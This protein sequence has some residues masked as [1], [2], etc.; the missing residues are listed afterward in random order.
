MNRSFAVICFTVALDA[1]GIGLVLPVL[2]G[3]LRSLGH[4]G[5]VAEHYGLLLSAY[6]LMQFLCSPVLGALSDRFGRR[7]VLLISLAGGAID[8]MVMAGSPFLW[9]LYATRIVAGVTG[10]NMAVAGAI[11]ADTTD[12]TTRGK[13]FG[14]MGAAFGVGFIAGPVLGGW[15]GEIS[16][17]APFVLASVLCALNFVM[18]FFALPE[19]SPLALRDAPPPWRWQAANP[20]AAL[21]GAFQVKALRPLL[22]I[23]GLVAI[24]GQVGASVWVIYGQDR[25]HWTP[26][27]V[28]ASMACFGLFHAGAQ[29]FVPGPL[30]KRFGERL[31]CLLS[32]TVDGGAYVFVGLMT[33]G[34]LVFAATPVFCLGAIA[35]P[36]LQALMTREVDEDGQ[37]QLQGNLAALTSLAGVVAPVGF[38]WLYALTKTA[39]PGVV[40]FAGASLYLICIPLLFLG[41]A[42]RGQSAR[43]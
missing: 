37:G 10:A 9:M 34:W 17:R 25:Y 15:M 41:W 18:A 8:Y 19:S 39:H 7:P 21:A 31:A 16:L 2:P 6:A 33:N 20:F 11:V 23:Y 38:T 22:V 14:Q 12:A 24:I 43:A 1:V 40:W 32:M 29:A 26:L 28:G 42:R 27:V 3:L 5:E 4:G 36:A 13:R 35:V 30:I